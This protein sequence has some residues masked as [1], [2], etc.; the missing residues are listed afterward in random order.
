MR[1]GIE[2]LRRHRPGLFA[3]IASWGGREQELL[4]CLV[5]RAKRRFKVPQSKEAEVGV[6]A[7]KIGRLLAKERDAVAV[8]VPPGFR[9]CEW[10][11]AR[12]NARMAAAG[13]DPPF[14]AAR[15]Q[16]VALLD[17]QRAVGR[18]RE[19]G[20]LGDGPGW[21]VKV[22]TGLTVVRELMVEVGAEL[23][24]GEEMER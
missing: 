14:P 18:M 11:I 22:A 4:Q 13:V 16:A 9:A 21:A 24:R 23:R 10:D 1:V 6:L 2:L 3:R 15:M 17:V 5:D 20:L 8:P 7:Y 12:A 19:A